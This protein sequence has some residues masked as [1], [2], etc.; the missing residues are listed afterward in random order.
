MRRAWIVGLA[1]VG[2]ALL[3][4]LPGSGLDMDYVLPRRLGKLGAMVIGGTA[5]AFASVAFQTLAG[6]RIL[7]PA[8]MGYEAVYL[9][10]QSLL[11]LTLGTASLTAL[12][13]HGNFAISILMM[14]GWSLLLQRWLFR[15]GRSDVWRLLLVGLVLTMVITTFTQFIQLRISP[16]EFAIYQSFAQVSFDR[17]DGARLA[18]SVAAL[19]VVILL[20]WR[21]LAVLDVLAFGRDQAVSLGVEHG[22][23]MRRIL[24]LISVLV[25]VST[26]LIGP[27]AFMGILVANLAWAMV[28][29][30]RHRR[31]LPMGAAIAVGLFLIAQ[32]LVEQA[33]NY[34]TTVGILVNLACGGWFLVL[35]LR[36]GRSE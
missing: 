22:R 6:N 16:G 17:V 1:L 15:D 5:V 28:P 18:W 4:L 30:V 12:G 33:F 13:P 32:I 20:G 2:L 19:G 27:T 10:W 29:G 14:F 9:M 23:A 11:I 3:Y 21:S 35:M 31:V 25:A 8:V 36:P 7:T 26:S 34:K 24:A